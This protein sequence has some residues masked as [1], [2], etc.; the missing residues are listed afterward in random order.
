MTNANISK[1][2]DLCSHLPFVFL[3]TVNQDKENHQSFWFSQFDNILQFYAG[4]NIAVF[5]SKLENYLNRGYWLAGYFTY[6]FG[7]FLDPALFFL[8]KKFNFP[9]AWL[10][11]CR[12]PLIQIKNKIKIPLKPT[13]TLA[14]LASN[15]VNIKNIKA[16][17]TQRDY[18]QNIEKIKQYLEQGLTYQVNYTFKLKFDFSGDIFN[19][20]QRLKRKQPTAYS[21]FINTGKN[22]FLSLSPELFFRKYRN[23]IYVRPMKGTITRGLDKIHDKKNISEF[24][25]CTKTKAENLMIVDLLRNDLGKIAKRVRTTKLFSVEKYNTLCQMTSTIKAS[26]NPQVTTKDIIAALFPSG[27]VTGAPKIKTMQLIAGLEKEPRGIYTGAIGYIA[28]NRDMCFNVAIRTLVLSKGKGELGI[29]GGI[30]YDSHDNHEYQEA[31]L[32]A[33]FFT[34][35]IKNP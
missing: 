5:F 2:P 27:S 32:K 4:D 14:R 21:A 3:D 8:R 12:E 33:K 35:A 6:E 17:V 1:K 9:L 30:V 10:G 7:Y 23:N 15:G 31:L 19:L 24:K 26:L 25:K 11:V 29:G 16:N 18:C 13:D 22:S 28:P 20:Y 34:N